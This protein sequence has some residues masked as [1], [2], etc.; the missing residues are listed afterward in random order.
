M[1]GSSVK[2]FAAGTGRS[3][4]KTEWLRLLPAMFAALSCLVMPPS[5]ALALEDGG[6]HYFGGNEDFGAGSWPPPGLSA[7]LTEL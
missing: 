6:S 5:G 2:T 7:N 4:Y 1:I 3:R